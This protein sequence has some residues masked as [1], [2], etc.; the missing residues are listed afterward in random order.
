MVL[1]HTSPHKPL[2][3]PPK[4][5]LTITE[6]PV[7]VQQQ[8]GFTYHTVFQDDQLI[9]GFQLATTTHASAAAKADDPDSSK[10][11]ERCV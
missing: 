5:L 10:G 7:I 4:E 3:S 2:P 1:L 9:P 11:P 6:D 8:I